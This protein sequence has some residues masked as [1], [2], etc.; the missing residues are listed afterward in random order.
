MEAIVG[1]MRESRRLTNF[2]CLVTVAL[3][4]VDYGRS[5]HL[6]VFSVVS[7]STSILLTLRIT[8]NLKMETDFAAAL[9]EKSG[10]SL[11]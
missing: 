7:A 1:L 11:T 6:A 3:I 5:E 8:L 4:I 10:L 9:Q 2:G